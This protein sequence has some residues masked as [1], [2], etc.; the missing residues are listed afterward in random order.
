[1][2]SIRSGTARIAIVPAWDRDDP[3]RDGLPRFPGAQV[4]LVVPEVE[5][6]AR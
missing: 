6:E 5:R 1:M 4:Q 2:I 3:L